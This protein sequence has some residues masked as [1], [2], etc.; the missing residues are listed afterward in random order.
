MEYKII[1]G[2]RVVR[3]KLYPNYGSTRDG[4][5]Y[6]WDTCRQMSVMLHGGNVAKMD[7]YLA[8]RSCQHGKARTVY[9]HVIVADCWVFNDD[10]VNKTQVNHKDGNKRNPSWLN[11]EWVT[12]AQN[13]RHAVDT[14][15]KGKGEELY[16]STLTDDQVHLVCQRLLDGH[17]PKDI[18]DTFGC[19]VDIVRKIRAGDTYFHIRRFYPVIHKYKTDFS[20]STVRWVCEKILD[21]MADIA[22]AKSSSNSALTPIDVK[23]IRYKIR[24][25]IISDEYF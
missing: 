12:P 11:L 6:R 20:E 7:N 18:A 13:Q 1:D 25:R 23:R 16:N 2:N 8:F 19:S 5:V 22:I 24:Y 9:V 14:E 15:L 3:S 21:G 10:P 4:L 17:R